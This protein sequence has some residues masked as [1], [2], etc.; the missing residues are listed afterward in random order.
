MNFQQLLERSGFGQYSGLFGTGEEVAR[1]LGF[2]GDQVKDFAQ[3]FQSFDRDR[4][5]EA[6]GKIPE[7]LAR[8]TG[9]LESSFQSGF[10]GLGQ[11]LGQATRQI[12][13]LAGKS[14]AVFGSTARQLS[15]A[16]KRTGET[17]Q[18]LL[19]K[20][21]TGLLGIQEQEGKERAALTSLLQN[22]VTGTFGRAQDI[23]A[24]DPDFNEQPA[25]TPT[26]SNFGGG[27]K[28]EQENL[29]ATQG[30]WMPAD[31]TRQGGTTP[32]VNPYYY[33]TNPFS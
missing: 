25:V 17:L 29:M 20:R 15:E 16:G 1:N 4:F 24:L 10:K 11:K 26:G 12:H 2:V 33:E 31:Y 6:A 14:G 19:R 28:V 30:G 21:D 9:T 3:Y 23:F 5:M 27:T 7:N 22:Y 13:G 18:D 32:Y 8:R